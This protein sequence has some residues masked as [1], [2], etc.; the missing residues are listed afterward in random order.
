MTVVSKFENITETDFDKLAVLENLAA[1]F[2]QRLFTVTHPEGSGYPNV[3]VPYAVPEGGE[4]EGGAL[5]GGSSGTGA[6]TASGRTEA[7][8]NRG[9]PGYRQPRRRRLLACRMAVASMCPDL[10]R[11]RRAAAASWETAQLMASTGIR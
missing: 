3:A 4:G 1:E 8:I 11:R 10:A 2:E 9:R 7:L 5:K 6:P